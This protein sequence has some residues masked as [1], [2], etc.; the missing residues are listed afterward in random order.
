MLD[1]KSQI[2]YSKENDD[3]LMKK[4]LIIL[5]FQ[6]TIQKKHSIRNVKYDHCSIMEI[7]I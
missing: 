6:R 4:M 3:L 2:P 1:L 7:D 5:L